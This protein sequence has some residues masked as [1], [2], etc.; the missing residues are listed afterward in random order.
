MTEVGTRTK[1]C[2]GSLQN[3]AGKLPGEN[4]GLVGSSCVEKDFQVSC[5]EG[6]MRRQE[7]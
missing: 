5:A 4:W 2:W 7:T 1:A 3:R 6:Y